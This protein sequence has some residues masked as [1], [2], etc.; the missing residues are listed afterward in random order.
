M[1]S[2]KM[3]FLP[4]SIIHLHCFHSTRKQRS[5]QD[6]TTTNSVAA[7]FWYSSSGQ[8]SS[9]RISSLLAAE[10]VADTVTAT[11]SAD[12]DSSGHGEGVLGGEAVLGGGGVGGGG[13][14]SGRGSGPADTAGL[15]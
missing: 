11:V 12:P 14:G 1:K 4:N 2:I 10:S 5:Y 6:R 9:S 13:G 7:F 8:T 15:G 3:N